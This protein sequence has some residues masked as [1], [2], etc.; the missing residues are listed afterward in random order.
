MKTTSFLSRQT[1]GALALGVGAVSPGWAQTAGVP[2]AEPVTVAPAA[3]AS[4]P[5]PA[6]A[7]AAAAAPVEPAAESTKVTRPGYEAAGIPVAQVFKPLAINADGVFVVP[8]ATVA[9]G[10]NSNMALKPTA[11]LGSRFDVVAPEVVATVPIQA[12]KYEL[13]LAANFTRY[14]SAS[15]A[16]TSDGELALS[17][18]NFLDV[19]NRVNWRLGYQSSH[20]AL[21]S[22][23]RSIAAVSPDQWHAQTL[24]GTYRYG[25]DGAQ[26]Q[27]EVDVGAS[28][29]RYANNRSTTYAADLDT[30]NLA[31]R[32]L[33][34]IEPKTQLLGE[35]KAT[36]NNYADNGAGLDNMDYRLFGGV[37]W[38]VTA[39]TSGRAKIGYEWKRFDGTHPSFDGLT[40]EAA[41]TWL[42][43][44]YSQFE[45]KLNRGA[46]DPTGDGSD[47]QVLTTGSLTWSHFWYSYLQ[48]SV[49]LN[50]GRATYQ[51]SARADN[52][53]ALALG[54]HYDAARWLRVGLNF[55]ASRRTSSLA[56]FEYHRS[57]TSLSVEASL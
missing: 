49:G 17:G 47:Y 14:D 20:D 40:M 21:G 27:I 10:H 35:L 6:P 2:A 28:H 44:S 7:P 51:G 57:L 24:S 45:L 36:D 26:G 43:R 22:T 13:S 39:S 56:A 25:A 18:E 16:D 23:D 37:V 34:R 9:F 5:A 11:A 3:A 31:G 52:L 50:L 53:S 1:L 48:T 42:P 19:R 54:V 15:A 8:K 32:F 55:E 4:A 38:D 29:K 41:M 30:A 12:Q 46:A 33:Y